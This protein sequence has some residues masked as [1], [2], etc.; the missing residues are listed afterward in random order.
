VR[1]RLSYWCCACVWI[2]LWCW[3][4]EKWVR[5]WCRRC[6]W[7]FRWCRCCRC[8][9][10]WCWCRMRCFISNCINVVI[11]CTHVY[12][13]DVVNVVMLAKRNEWRDDVEGVD[14]VDD[15]VD[16]VDDGVDDVDDADDGVDVGCFCSISNCIQCINVYHSNIDLIVWWVMLTR[17][18][19]DLLPS[20]PIIF[21]NDANLCVCVIWMKSGSEVM[22][23]CINICMHTNS[24]TQ[25]HAH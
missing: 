24:H 18:S 20:E 4:S 6:R 3:R 7:W 25:T 1:T 10:R 12:H 16:D 19:S 22:N 23:K 17:G 21:A 15:G 13:I 14:D 5:R 11:T 8:C 9:R 2:F